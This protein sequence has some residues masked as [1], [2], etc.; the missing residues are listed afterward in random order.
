MS[1]QAQLL[2]LTHLYPVFACLHLQFGG[3]SVL[4]TAMFFIIPGFSIC[5]ILYIWIKS[6]HRKLADG[7]KRSIWFFVYF[8]LVLHCYYAICVL[9]SMN[10]TGR[11][12]ILEHNSFLFYFLCFILIFYT[13]SSVTKRLWH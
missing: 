7:E 12:W 9:A 8:F 4:S 2:F 1:R 11:G 5:A 13:L 3:G 6:S 10:N